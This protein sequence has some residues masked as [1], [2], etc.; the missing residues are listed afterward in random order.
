MTTAPSTPTGEQF[1][2]ASQKQ[3]DALQQTFAAQTAEG[4]ETIDVLVVDPV[5]GFMYS[6]SLGLKELETPV[7]GEPTPEPVVGQ[8]VGSLG[9]ATVTDP[10]IRFQETGSD[11][12]AVRRV[13][14]KLGTTTN[15]YS[16]IEALITLPESSN[17]DWMDE[18]GEAAYNYLG[19]EHMSDS[20]GQLVILDAGLVCYPSSDAH[21]VA[22]RWYAYAG[23]R[24]ATSGIYDQQAMGGW[25]QGGIPGDQQL[26]MFLEARRDVDPAAE[27]DQ[28]GFFLHIRY[29]ESKQYLMVFLDRPASQGGEPLLGIPAN[30]LNTAVRRVSSIIWKS[31]SKNPR[32]CGVEWSNVKVG[33]P[34]DPLHL[35]GP[36]DLNTTP[37]NQ[38]FKSHLAKVTNNTPYHTETL[39]LRCGPGVGM[40]IDTTGSMGGE[41]SAVKAALNAFTSSPFAELV[42]NWTLSTFKDSPTS[43]GLTSDLAAVRS[44]V[45]G[46][47]ASGGGDC[48]EDSFGGL[49][50]AANVL[51]DAGP[52]RTLILVTDASPRPG[53]NPAAVTARLQE[54]DITLHVLLTGDCVASSST[55]LK[56][57]EVRAQT[58]PI[59]SARDVFSRMAADTGGKYV[60]MPGGSAAAFTA[61]LTDFFEDAATGGDDTEPPTLAITVSPETIWPPNHKMVEVDVQVEVEDNVDSDPVVEIVGVASSE[62][63]D[64]QG[65]GNT[66]P[67]FEILPS[68][69]IFVRAERSG[70]GQRRIYTITYKAT[71]D[72]GNMS[73]AS[74]DVTVPH[75]KGKGKK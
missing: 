26:S 52:E 3:I 27:G 14:T 51:E 46:L 38:P 24:P 30:G 20:G 41:I 35:F 70:T 66:S 8:A 36:D 6:E 74:A 25:P 57:A 45:A 11:K 7:S 59:L 64:I 48:P 50:Q 43:Y 49:L 60:Y 47:S 72:A 15:P 5:A 71:D 21:H 34:Q 63:D 16:R 73:T 44:W 2:A 1:I 10:S 12:E 33:G 56:A 42:T 13:P 75:D 28:R 18:S 19:L 54:L 39:D 40:V 53:G 9:G 65:S 29:Q 22:G 68:G 61:V 62:P 58:S 55:L 69:K 67:D 32:M 17:F 31:T 37:P 23:Y 4:P